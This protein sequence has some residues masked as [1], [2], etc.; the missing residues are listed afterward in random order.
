MN[1]FM[2]LNHARYFP[3]MKL[4]RW[5]FAYRTGF[6]KAMPDHRTYLS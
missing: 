4:G 5:V 3:Y 1:M 2:Q 6:I